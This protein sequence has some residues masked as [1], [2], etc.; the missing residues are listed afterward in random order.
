MKRGVAFAILGLSLAG[1]LGA[2]GGSTNS[3]FSGDP[4]PATGNPPPGGFD[5]KNTPDAAA[6][7]NC[8][9]AAKLVY[10]VSQ[11]RDLYSFTPNLGTFAKIGRITCPSTNPTLD[12][13][14]SMAIDR[15]G[16]A[17]VN[18]TDGSLFKVSTSDASCTATTFAKSQ[19]GFK[20]FGMAFATN[21]AGSTDE[22]LFVSGISDTGAAGKGFGKLDLGTLKITMLGEYSDK[23]AGVF[24]ELT[25][26]GDGHLYGFFHTTPATFAE[27][28][29]TN[30]ATTNDKSLATVDAG[31]DFAFSFW[32]GDFWFYTSDGKTPSKVT[33]LKA[34]STGELVVA[35]AD[36]GGFR[37]TGAGVST[38]AP[39]A[40]PH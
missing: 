23:L 7:D 32:G 14:A 39:V 19:Q 33:Q 29:Q 5:V 26:T 11:E 2:C 25:G 6:V 12:V 31:N 28:N 16:T 9:A 20:K 24:P 10:V 18:Y 37:I 22:T 30:G 3:S 15:S 38:C 40:P 4:P 35:K 1:V 13:P 8:T 27:I 34:S 36:V 17:W 21:A